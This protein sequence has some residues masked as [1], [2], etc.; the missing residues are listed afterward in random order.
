MGKRSQ[1]NFVRRERDFYATPELPILKLLPFLKDVNTF[2]EPMCGDGAIINT[3]EPLGWT[4]TSCFDMEPQDM[5]FLRAGTRMVDDLTAADFEGADVII[6]NPPWPLPSSL[7]PEG[8]P[9]GFPTVA[10]IEH[11]MQ[12][13]PTWL[14]MSADFKHNEYA[15]PL[16][17]HCTHEVSAG[18]VKWIADSANTGKDNASWYRFHKSESGPPRFFG[19]KE[20]K[21]LFHPS[22]EDVL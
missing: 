21:R 18:R 3:L 12:F 11:L 1:G 9:R 20:G 16:L 2:C 10:I 4:C 8:A 14:I 7:S 13:R 6:S 17:E 5:M 19:N 15:L 22:I